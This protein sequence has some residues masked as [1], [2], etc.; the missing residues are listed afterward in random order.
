MSI[1]ETCGNCAHSEFVTIE[2]PTRGV[3]RTLAC[4]VEGIAETCANHACDCGKFK[5]KKE[6]V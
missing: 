6:T 1:P 2:S 4:L 3:Y 5:S